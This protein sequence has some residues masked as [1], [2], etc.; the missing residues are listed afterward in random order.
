MSHDADKEKAKTHRLRFGQIA[1]KMGFISGQ[2]LKDAINEQIDDDLA[3]RNHRFIGDILLEKQ[4]I[5]LE[6][7]D[8]ILDELFKEEMKIKGVL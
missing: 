1:V 3:G 5:N 6:Q 7:V 4:W 8:I 2:Q